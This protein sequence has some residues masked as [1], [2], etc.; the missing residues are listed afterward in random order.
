MR[1][2]PIALSDL[3]VEFIAGEALDRG[4]LRTLLQ[5]FAHLHW[6]SMRSFRPRNVCRSWCDCSSI[7]WSSTSVWTRLIAASNTPSSKDPC[8]AF[9]RRV[10]GHAYKQAATHQLLTLLYRQFF[11]E[12]LGSFSGGLG[13]SG[14]IQRLASE[15]PSYTPSN[16]SRR[17][18]EL[19]DEGGLEVQIRHGHALHRVAQKEPTLF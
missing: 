13:A 19:H 8:P 1:L 11:R 2:S 10:G 14:C 17:L 9:P 18:R 15:K 6:R 5:N 12:V 4:T 7:F 3:S 16:V